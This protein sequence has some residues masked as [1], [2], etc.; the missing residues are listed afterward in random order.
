MDTSEER[1]L[2][3]GGS[4]WPV[5]LKEYFLN[6]MSFA[7]DFSEWYALLEGITFLLKVEV[8]HGVFSEREDDVLQVI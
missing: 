3:G 5:F 2:R 4:E 1:V 7:E 6:A 8:V